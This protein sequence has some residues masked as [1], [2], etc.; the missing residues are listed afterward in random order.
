[1]NSATSFFT[2]YQLSTYLLWLGPCSQ[3]PPPQGLPPSLQH[4]CYK[5]PQPAQTQLG[6]TDS[7]KNA[8]YIGNKNLQKKYILYMKICFH[9]CVNALTTQST[10]LLPLFIPRFK[11]KSISR[12]THVV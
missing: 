10:S 1:M 2:L 9:L 12:M 6:Y 8:Q 3:E 4:H 11:Y 5:H 7:E